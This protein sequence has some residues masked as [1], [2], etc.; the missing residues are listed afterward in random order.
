ME[1]RIHQALDLGDGPAALRLARAWVSASP[2]QAWPWLVF[3]AVLARMGHER[4]A[5]R[6]ATRAANK[7]LVVQRGRRDAHIRVLTLVSL[8]DAAGGYLPGHGFRLGNTT[9]INDSLSGFARETV[10]VLGGERIPWTL[11]EEHGP[12]S[13]VF[14]GI[15]VAERASESLRQVEEIVARLGLRVI[16]DPSRVRACSRASNWLRLQSHADVRFPR[17]VPVALEEGAGKARRRLPAS[18]VRE[19]GFEYPVI[20]RWPGFQAGRGMVRCEGPEDLRSLRWPAHL[21]EA[22]VIEYVDFRSVDGY[23]RKA[24]VFAIAGSLLPRHLLV[25]RDWKI[26]AGDGTGRAAPQEEPWW[27][28]E[29]LAFVNDWEGWAGARA[30]RGLADVSRALGLEYCGIDFSVLPDGRV[31]VFEANPAMNVHNLPGPGPAPA[32]PVFAGLD[33][34]ERSLADAIEN[35]VRQYATVG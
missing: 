28:Q 34:L 30:V 2:G 7:G 31:L 5:R 22:L 8:E 33:R 4:E 20:V 14:N 1:N 3:S 11:L 6:A 10:V 15:T 18:V 17:T 27:K 23:Y 24:R 26:H 25:R 16:N 13:V 21:R 32:G 12:Y 19:Q 29:M 9:D 35:M